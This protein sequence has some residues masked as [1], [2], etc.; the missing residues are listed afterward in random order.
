MPTGTH[1]ILVVEDEKAIAEGL[2]ELL[3]YRGYAPE[4]VNRG[5]EAMSAIC[6]RRFDLVILDVMLPGASGFEICG[7]LRD[8]DD[9]VPVLMLTARGSEEDIL[10]GFRAGC[11]DYVTKPFSVAELSARVEALLRRRRDAPAEVFEFGPWRIDSAKLLATDG[12]RSLELSRRETELLAS[13]VREPGRIVSRRALLRDL[14]GFPSPERV[15]TRTVDMHI[16]KLRKK[17]GKQGGR[18]I[19]TVRGEGYRLR[20]SP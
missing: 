20:V 9:E 16:A 18:L 4:V 14:W 13:L 5:D 19:E 10:R 6:S 1:S 7:S 17:L 3:S 2:R 12:Q 8:R 15:E 11:D